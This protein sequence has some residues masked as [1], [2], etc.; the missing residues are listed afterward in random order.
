MIAAPVVELPELQHRPD[1][2]G[3]GIQQLCRATPASSTR[4]D[5]SE[6]DPPLPRSAAREL[7]FT[8]LISGRIA[9]GES[10]ELTIDPGSG[11]SR[12]LRA[13]YPTRSLSV[14]VRGASGA[15]I[16]LDPL[17]HGSG[18]SADAS[19]VFL[20]SPPPGSNGFNNPDLA[21]G[22]SLSRRRVP[23]RAKARRLPSPRVSS[24][25]QRCMPGSTR[26]CRVYTKA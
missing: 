9:A 17:T 25:A 19:V 5:T 16:V 22:K 8:K 15:A 4:H 10:Q 26:R 12:Q 3:S 11:S 18:L 23:H 2:F 20:L 14:Q 24:A 6:P 1:R 13:V 7:Q 21:R